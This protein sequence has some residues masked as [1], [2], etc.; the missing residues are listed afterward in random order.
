MTAKGS[1]IVALKN[2]GPVTARQ[3]AALGIADEAA[4]RRIGPVAA[5]RR[6]KFANPR[7]ITLVALYALHGALT[8]THWCALPAEVKGALRREAALEGSGKQTIFGQQG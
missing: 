1:G 6:L 5:Y 2:L 3:L 4:L 7:G 8:D